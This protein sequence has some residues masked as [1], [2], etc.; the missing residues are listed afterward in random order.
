MDPER[1]FVVDGEKLSGGGGVAEMAPAKH[2]V[3]CV[4]RQATDGLLKS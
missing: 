3:N 4:K 1:E 2:D